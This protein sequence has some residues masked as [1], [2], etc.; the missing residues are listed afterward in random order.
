V[1]LSIRLRRL[2]LLSLLS[3][4]LG[5]AMVVVWSVGTGPALAPALVALAALGA[6]AVAAGG[7]VAE[8]EAAEFER[9]LAEVGAAVDALSTASRRLARD[10]RA[11]GEGG[12][13][14][15]DAALLSPPSAASGAAEAR[16][17]A[18]RVGRLFGAHGELEGAL[19]A[20]AK[21]HA[22]D[23]AE[24]ARA[25]RHAEALLDGVVDAA[26]VVGFDGL[27]VELNAVARGLLGG[28]RAAL[29]GSSFARAFAERDA[30]TTALERAR[31]QGVLRDC[32]LSLRVGDGERV[33]EVELTAGLLPAE[34]GQAPALLV[35]LRDQSAARR[36]A[37]EGA[38]RAQYARSLIE[39]AA[40][41]L[42]AINLEGDITD[43]NQAAA[44][45]TG[46]A[47]ERLIGMSF[48]DLFTDPAHAQ[49]ANA[50]VVAGG[51]VEEVALT[52]K[53]RDGVEVP[54]SLTATLYRDQ[55]A[56]VAGIM[57]ALRDVTLVRRAEQDRDAKEWV[58]LG[59]ARLNQRFQEQASS[60]DLS[61]RLVT[62]LAEYAGA[63]V[64][65]L[66][67]VEGDGPG[68]SLVLAASHAYVRRK[69]LSN[70]FALGEGILGQ[71]ALERR[72]LLVR[73][74]PED[75]LHIASGLADGLPRSLCVTPLIFEGGVKA[76]VELASVR[77]FTD[78]ALDY[79][80]QSAPAI[81]VALEAAFARERIA[82]ALER[83]Q[84]LSAELE[85][86]QDA[87]RS[88][89]A[90]L[91][92]QTAALKASEQKL[93]A[94][95]AEIELSN[96]E[97]N[98]KNELLER[99][100]SETE[101]ARQVLAE[102]AEE[103]ALA[104]KYKSE[105]LANM[106]HEL[107]TPLNSLLL[108]ARSLRENELGNLSEDQVESARV[109]FDSGSDLLNLIN[110]ILDLS[111][112]EAGKMD[113]RLEEVDLGELERSLSSQFDHMARAQGLS[114]KFERASGAPERIVTDPQ[115]LGQIVKNLLG[116]AIKFTEAGGVTVRIERPAPGVMLRRSALDHTQ[117]LAIHVTDTGIGIP[118]DKQRIIFEA[119]QQADSG[120]RRRFGG[121]GLGLSISRELA[122]LLG[123]EIQLVS[124]V[125]H[126]STFTLY[127]PL[128]TGRAPDSPR[129]LR[130]T[131]PR[132]A[133]PEAASAAPTLPAP[134]EPGPLA[135]FDDRGALSERDHVVLVI[136]DDLRFAKQ[137]AAPIRAR[138]LKCLLASSGEEG[139]MLARRHRVHGVVLDIKLPQMD[140]WAVLNTLKQDVSLRHIP[141]HIVS[142]D[143]HG[144]Q[145]I[146]LGAIG[147][148]SKPLSR[149]RIDEVLARLAAASAEANKRVLVVE[150]D[151][152]LRK[153]TVR[154]IGNGAVSVEEVASGEAA[155]Q[156]LRRERFHLV[157]MDL[158]LPDM[159][160][161][162]LLKRVT[163]EKIHLPPIIVH[164]VRA[165]TGE[166][167]MFLRAYA[168]SIIV[169]DVRSQERLIDEVAL[170]LHRVVRDLPEENRRAIM[171]LHASDEPLR[172]KK[173]LVVEDDMRTMFAMAR[174][175]AGHGVNPLKAEN[176]E[177]ALAML[178]EH[179]D[180]DLVLMDMMMPVMDGYEATRRIRETRSTSSLPVVALTAKAMKEDRQR[181]LDVGAT[182]Y[183]SKPVDPDRLVSLLRV[184]LS[185]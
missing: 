125:G 112:I 169:K 16:D 171:Q 126:G 132:L 4:T 65:A 143:E 56:A 19:A 69:G 105:F 62:E 163:A 139:L 185:R 61:R 162:D 165:L 116:N 150:D 77:P 50:R 67:I 75:Y 117:A 113:L 109:I 2:L 114:L 49:Q 35:L 149:E 173:I 84:V 164:T 11:V 176:G 82:A 101:Q 63:Q 118:L 52:L 73:D 90:E 98:T 96:S 10:A 108:L 64:G 23:R 135:E 137:I 182:D 110:E 33:R 152:R 124:S 138:G 122:T 153:E 47:R 34:S 170:F 99:Q 160:G 6:A 100:R 13:A 30:A 5:A 12:D 147:H 127:L 92:E 146:R 51:R 180:T 81:A 178:A 39:A 161:F 88:T 128:T 129:P 55:N 103:V 48:H 177:R 179:P 15:V 95:Q 97:L 26:M 60:A 29:R 174:M 131:S 106:S 20:F 148:A 145:P 59:V 22:R 130:G 25:R 8:R 158:G 76:M 37:R 140:G 80:R 32:Q 107:R 38:V 46:V 156:A 120:D 91:E 142:A 79:L 168:D 119:F 151:E 70:R 78:A 159:Q 134:A 17:L 93:R 175:L 31:S 1:T 42:L 111:K 40:D 14:S 86:Q 141:V 54:V 53:R 87:L 89:N 45:T 157:V 121:T 74:L 27:I 123:G 155:L 154:I 83:S 71:A 167:E 115:R 66:Y 36:E 144:A 21:A 181:C 183:L 104:S 57:I 172:G 18:L 28:D 44:Q 7:L 94:Q 133:A 184:L 24:G 166:E 136:E 3:L 68:A 58:M 85:A 72:Q 9:P 43:V 41:P 102:Q